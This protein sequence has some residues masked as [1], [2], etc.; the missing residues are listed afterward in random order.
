MTDG[1]Q[2]W[3]QATEAELARLRWMLV[4]CAGLAVVGPVLVL[5]LVG[6]GGQGDLP[7]PA[8]PVGDE[9]IVLRDA[10]GRPRVELRAEPVPLLR[11]LDE[12]GETRLV[13]SAV[14]EGDATVNM[15]TLENGWIRFGTLGGDLDISMV[16]RDGAELEIFSG[17]P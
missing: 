1:M 4:G 11:L 12:Q 7:G 2:A 14:S 16:D 13:M 8:A 5:W 15:W 3:V 6:A 9:A 10:D 17:R